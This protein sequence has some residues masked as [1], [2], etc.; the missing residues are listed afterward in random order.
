MPAGLENAWKKYKA[1]VSPDVFEIGAITIKEEELN[2]IQASIQSLQDLKNQITKI[3]VTKLL[4]IFI[5]G[6]LKIG[7][8]DV[9]FEPEAK[10]TRVRYRLDGYLQDAVFVE[11][12]DYKKVV[13]RVKVLAQLKLNIHDTPQDGRFTIRQK[14]TDVEVRVSVLPSEYGETIV[15]RLLDPR[16][17]MGKIEELGMRDDIL[18]LV[19]KQLDKAVGVILTTGPTG[20]GKT[21]TLYSFVNYLNTP[22]TK[23]ITIEDPI[24]YHIT[25]ISQTQVE[26][27]KGYTFVNGLRAIVRQDPD[28]VLVGE[29]RDLETAEIAMQ[30][31]LT[32]HIVLSTLHTNDAAGTIPRLVDLGVKSQTIAPALNMA[33]AQRLL[34]KLCPAC[35]KATELH[36]EDLERIKKHMTPLVER[37]KLPMVD[38]KLVVYAPQGCKECNNL[39]FKGRIGV[40]EAFT[41]SREMEFLILKNAPVSEIRDRAI[42]EGMVTFMQDAFL[43]LI[44]GTTALDEI[45][46]VLGVV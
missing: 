38:D 33:M 45:Y 41:I 3:S 22:D 27:E 9:H 23:I 37:F 14:D 24:E 16:R 20:S 15:M 25:G 19:K 39:G 42:E 11:T 28:V 8:S 29:I 10:N 44:A 31:A 18:A 13:N 17:V 43:K 21:T 2:Q 7:A 36:G 46:R 32:G 35:K 40:Y 34:R 30:A 4:E 26:P 5:G 1:I 6:A 12:K